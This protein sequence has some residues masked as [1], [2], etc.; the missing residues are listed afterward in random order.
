ASSVND[1]DI[2]CHFE[3]EYMVAAPPSPCDFGGVSGAFLAAVVDRNP[4]SH[5]Q[6]AG[7]VYEFQPSL[8]ILKAHRLD[9]NVLPTG[10][11]QR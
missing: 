7:V 6:P 3:R 11:L 4:I 1:R 10:H 2:T 9:T 5:W 8:E